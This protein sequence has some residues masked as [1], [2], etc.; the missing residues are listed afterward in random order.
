MHCGAVIFDARKT[1]SVSNILL[2]YEGYRFDVFTITPL[3]W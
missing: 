2:T 1:Q 3:V